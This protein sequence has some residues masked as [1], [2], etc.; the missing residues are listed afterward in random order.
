MI[1][2]AARHQMEDS[3]GS[4][5]TFREAFTG[6][7]KEHEAQALAHPSRWESSLEVGSAGFY[8]QSAEGLVLTAVALGSAH[9]STFR[10][11]LP[12]LL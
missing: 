2:Q 10:P 12:L 4:P 6:E 8:S 3:V 11:L 5:S 7:L 1:T 9:L